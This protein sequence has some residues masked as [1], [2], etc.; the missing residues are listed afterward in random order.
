MVFIQKLWRNILKQSV[1]LKQSKVSQYLFI[2]KRLSSL[3]NRCELKKS[4]IKK[5][6]NDLEAMISMFMLFSKSF[7]KIPLHDCFD[8][9]V[10]FFAQTVLF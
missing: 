8:S 6:L 10:F 4:K 1:I 7:E 9:Q 3:K 2:H 5:Y